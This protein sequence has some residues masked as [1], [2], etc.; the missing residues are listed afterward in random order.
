MLRYDCFMVIIMTLILDGT[1]DLYIVIQHT[2]MWSKFST[3]THEAVEEHRSN[4]RRRTIE[5]EV[6][7]GGQT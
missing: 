7:D 2:N 1:T 6:A 3:D 4:T 5:I